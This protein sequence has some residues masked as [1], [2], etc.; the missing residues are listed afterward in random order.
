MQPCQH[1]I[2]FVAALL[3]VAV[4]ISF[5]CEDDLRCGKL[6]NHF[7]YYSAWIMFYGDTVQ[8]TRQLFFLSW[9]KYRQH[10][11]LL[12]LEKQ[13]VDVIIAHPEYHA[14]LEAT[15]LPKEQAYFP[16][17]GQTNP[18]LHM[19]LHLAIR[20]QIA[21]DRPAGITNIYNQ[22]VLKYTDAMMV[23]HLLMDF[24]AESLWL[25]QRN[26]VMP[27]EANYLQACR[28]LLTEK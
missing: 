11:P 17:L 20:D 21:T 13:I 7:F 8:D 6:T 28:Q 5:V 9:R 12:P 27:D 4:L 22:L 23:E 14:L 2:I 19:G 3:C 18:F 1:E 24:L 16:E 10:Q 15:D 25:A 26:Q